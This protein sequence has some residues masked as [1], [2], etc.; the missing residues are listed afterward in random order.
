MS[1]FAKDVVRSITGS[2]GRFLAILGIVALGC[3][4]YAGL[5]MTGEDMRAAADAFYDGTALYDLRLLSSLGFSEEQVDLV[6]QTDGVADV[7]AGRSTDVMA[8]LHG[9]QYAMR[10]SSLDVDAA[11]ASSVDGVVVSSADPDYLN[12]LVLAEGSWPD[13]PGEC[14]LSADRVMGDPI[15]VGDT[16]QVLYGARDLDGVLATRTFTVTGLVHSSSFVSSV[17]LGSTT[18]GSGSIQQYLYV[19]PA[20]FD[21]GCPYT[22]V[23]AKVDGADAHLAGSDAYQ[24]RVDEV[25]DR[26]AD[27]SDALAASRLEDLRSSAQ[28]RL[29][30]QKASY[31]D[32]ARRATDELD[33]AEAQLQVA[34]C[35]LASGRAELDSGWSAWRQGAEML[36]ARRA[37]ASERLAQAHAQLVDDQ[38]RVDEG[39]AVLDAAGTRLEEGRAQVEEL[40]GQADALEERILELEAAGA[41]SEQTEPLEAQLAELRER[42]AR[43][44]GALDQA[45]R[46]LDAQAAELTAARERLQEGWT[47]YRDQ[48]AAAASQLDAAASRLDESRDRLVA[49]EEE[50]ASSAV[51]YES[52]REAYQTMRNE[53]LAQLSDAAQVLSNAQADIDELEPPDIYVLDR[54][55][56][57]GV[58]SYQADSERMD[59]IAAV[60]PFIFF[61]VAALVALTTM[62]RMVDE[63]RVLIGTYRALGYGPGRIVSKY[64]VYAG[65]ASVVGALLGIAA[66]SQVLPWTIA[67]AYAI[68][69]NVPHQPF[70]LPV[71]ASIAALSACLGVGATLLAT[72]AAVAAT[73]REQPAALMLP[74]APKPGRRI[75][76][77]RIG[78]FWRRVS[79]SRKVT[80]RNLFRYR[81]RFWMTVVGI[82]GCTALLLTG[83]GLHDAIWDIIDRQFD[84][85][86]HY[87]AT[88][89]L[90]SDATRDQFARVESLLEG[91][92][93]VGRV[94][95]VQL[96]NRKVGSEGHEALSA[97]VVTPR[98][99]GGFGDFVSL[100]VRASGEPVVFDADS[101]VL[102]EKLAT[103]LG[104]GPGDTVGF[105]ELDEVGDATGEAREL[106]VSGVTESYIGN[107]AYLGAN[108]RRQVTGSDPAYTS[109]FVSCSGDTARHEQLAEQLHDEGGV[110]TVSFND[111]TIDNY[112]KM[113]RSVD[114]I[115]VVLVVSAAALAFIVLYNLTNINIDERRREIATLKVLGF[116]RRE[117][118]AY[119]HRETIMLTVFGALLGLVLGVFLEHFVVVTAEV[120]Y[121]MFGRT[122]H[123][124]SFLLAFVLTLVFSVLVMLIMRRKLDAIGMAESLKSVD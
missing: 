59:N 114:M 113:L 67:E 30:E 25:A 100:R 35:E 105:Y 20:S 43:T 118:G 72:W 11:D 83:F 47:S 119:V 56:N 22:E 123:P 75:L 27:S 80:F 58:A 12:R 53:T 39:Q 61:L 41:P 50:L 40:R 122:I 76:L 17:S 52:G 64:L 57:A 13:E 24:A 82:A 117:V 99:D 81:K 63:D 33:A 28:H 38:A 124:P 26:L 104:V 86:V 55:K 120:D 107:Q 46:E 36:D 69:Y 54:T 78:P 77:E 111:E 32:G 7:M 70:P 110:Q 23:F 1:A 18:L 121:V 97:Q 84:T 101:V 79:F 10:V 45:T 49:G 44:E 19:A 6:A 91:Q 94:A 98:D 2:L 85:V 106:V 9:E 21:D 4:F 8:E 60:F 62:T 51:S 116:T 31:E 95:R 115:V 42:L 37:E 34:A 87:N 109:L 71:D 3:G 88:V 93:D 74:R 73:M 92:D 96:D 68:I 65:L 108:A 112:R 102:S 89:T 29:D 66:L 15:Q 103:T 48:E 16:V 5:R 14:V 90:S